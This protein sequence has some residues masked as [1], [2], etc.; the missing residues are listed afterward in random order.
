MKKGAK[1][2]IGTENK[3]HQNMKIKHNPLNSNISIPYISNN[4]M[5]KRYDKTGCFMV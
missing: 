1:N 2:K 5:D 4:K 3:E